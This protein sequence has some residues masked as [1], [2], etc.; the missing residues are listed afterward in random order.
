MTGNSVD[1]STLLTSLQPTVG[2]DPVPTARLPFNLNVIVP[3][4][5]ATTVL[6]SRVQ[7][8]AQA[9]TDFTTNLPPNSSL[10]LEYLLAGKANSGDESYT[11]RGSID[12][13]F[14]IGATPQQILAATASA[15]DML[16]QCINTALGL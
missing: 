4:S 12:L 14:V 11:I 13:E 6:P 16:L 8:V 15:Q 3:N 2:Q 9:I 1:I 7:V 10:N 5:A